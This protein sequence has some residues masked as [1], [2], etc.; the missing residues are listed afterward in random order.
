MTFWPAANPLVSVTG[1]LREPAG[2]VMY[3]PS[4]SGCHSGVLLL[5]GVPTL[6]ILRVSAPAPVSLC[7]VSPALRP[8]VLRTLRVVSPALA[9]A[10]SP[11]VDRPST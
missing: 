9:G 2:I 8:V 4:G 11:E 5:A 1:T 6:A 3:G 7:T 10:A